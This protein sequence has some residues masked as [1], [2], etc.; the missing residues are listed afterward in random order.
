MIKNIILDIGGVLAEEV[1]GRALAHL[2]VEEQD[3]ISSLLYFKSSGFIEVLLG[4]ESSADYSARMIEKYPNLKNEISFLFDPKNLPITYPIKR[5]ILDLLYKLHNTYKIYFLSDMIDMSY[6]Y[7]KDI[8]S[9]FDGG[10]YSFQEHI[11]KPNPEFFKILLN[12]YQLNPSETIFFD[13]KEK[14]VIAAQDLGM[15]AAVFA[16]IDSIVEALKL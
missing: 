7:I 16:D 4:N 12:R 10:A 8:L 13:D 14:N 5:D 1:N 3:D 6:N 2:T 15:K 11:K 9:D